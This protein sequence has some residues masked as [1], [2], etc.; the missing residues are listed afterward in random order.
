MIDGQPPDLKE[1]IDYCPFVK[2]CTKAMKNM[3]AVDA[4]KD[5]IK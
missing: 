5:T 2:R 4:R 3:Y 1:S